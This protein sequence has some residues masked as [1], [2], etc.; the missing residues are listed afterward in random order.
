MGKR[1]SCDTSI[2]RSA[3]KALSITLQI[4][5]LLIYSEGDLNAD[6]RVS[7]VHSSRSA[8][9]VWFHSLQTGRAVAKAVALKNALTVS[10]SG[11][12]FLKVWSVSISM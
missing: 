5:P 6:R 1:Y 3:V 7:W 9:S 10:L 2:L 11:I 8:V 12:Y 4:L